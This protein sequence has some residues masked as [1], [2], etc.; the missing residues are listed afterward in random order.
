M[1]KEKIEKKSFRYSSVFWRQCKI[2]GRIGKDFVDGFGE[3]N[4]NKIQLFLIIQ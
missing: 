3:R 2:H 1:I 4:K